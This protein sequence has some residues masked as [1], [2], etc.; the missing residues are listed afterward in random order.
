M[1]STA[2]RGE[3][4]HALSTTMHHTWIRQCRYAKRHLSRTP[5][6]CVPYGI[7]VGDAAPGATVVACERARSVS[8]LRTTFSNVN[9]FRAEMG[10]QFRIK[11]ESSMRSSTK[12]RENQQESL[13]WWWP[14]TASKPGRTIS[15]VMHQ[16]FLVPGD[17]LERIVRKGP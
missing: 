14:P 4:A 17:A 3:Q 2:Q 1:A 5:C 15:L 10:G 16:K 7:G 9:R 11:T 8:G 13:Q 6:S 12:E